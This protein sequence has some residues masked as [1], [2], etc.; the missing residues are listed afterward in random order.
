MSALT[1]DS[2]HVLDAIERSGSFAAAAKEL[3]R[4]PSTISYAVSKLEEDLGVRV[5]DRAGPRVT[6]TPAGRALLDEGR[7][8]LLAAL[9]LEHKVRRVARGWETEFAIA[10]DV[11]FSPVLLAPEIRDFYTAADSTRLRLSQEALS[12]T[13]EV[14]LDG[15]ADLVVGAAGEGPPG[16]GYRTELIGQVRFLFVVAP[17]HPLAAIDRPLNKADLMA[18]RMISVADSARRLPARTVGLLAGQDTLTVPDLAEKF[19]FQLA[20]LGAGFLPEPW[21][22][23]AISRGLLVEKTVDEERAAEHFYL[24]WRTGERGAALDWWLQRL[25]RTDL[26][27]RF[28]GSAAALLPPLQDA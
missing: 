24:A 14:L 12:G 11:L 10:T 2:L 26:M 7:P 19:R 25:R 27:A 22:R 1:L 16:G 18:H 15:R 23:A 13:W 28:A 17:S 21:A 20:G 9:Q 8:L 4:V 3:F 6:L 5:F